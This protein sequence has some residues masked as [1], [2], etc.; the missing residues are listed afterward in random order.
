[1]KQYLITIINKYQCCGNYRVDSH[2]DLTQPENYFQCIEDYGFLYEPDNGDV[3]NV[4][5]LDVTPILFP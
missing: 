2:L 3:V 1:M 5:D 4:V